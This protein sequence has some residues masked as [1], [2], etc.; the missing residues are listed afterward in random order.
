MTH[1]NSDSSF[2]ESEFENEIGVL[3]MEKIGGL[4]SCST[5]NAIIR[6]ADYFEHD[7]KAKIFDEF[8]LNDN[9]LF[10]VIVYF[11]TNMFTLFIIDR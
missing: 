1:R 9:T 4:L 5:L 3:G 7:D 6:E 11:L 8:G 2:E 10:K